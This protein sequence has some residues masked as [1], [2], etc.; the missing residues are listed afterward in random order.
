MDDEWTLL[1]LLVIGFDQ[2]G[3][4]L[5]YPLRFKM[6]CWVQLDTYALY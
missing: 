1:Y 4:E 3:L 6:F 5:I 2:L